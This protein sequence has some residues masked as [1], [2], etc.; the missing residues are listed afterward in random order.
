VINAGLVITMLKELRYCD[1]LA[2][3]NA[4]EIRD[5]DGGAVLRT[6]SERL[7][8]S[9]SLQASRPSA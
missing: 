2:L 4:M 3:P 7:P 8:L 6:G 5:S 1:W 9:Y